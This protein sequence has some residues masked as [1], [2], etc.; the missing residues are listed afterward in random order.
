MEELFEELFD[1]LEEYINELDDETV[2]R[3]GEKRQAEYE[4]AIK[5][6]NSPEWE[7][8]AYKAVQDGD[9]EAAKEVGSERKAA[10]ANRDLRRKKLD[11]FKDL[12]AKRRSRKFQEKAAIE[13]F[14][15]KLLN[16]EPQT[17]AEYKEAARA[18]ASAQIDQG[19]RNKLEKALKVSNECLDDIMEMIEEYING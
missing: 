16:K 13:R 14:R 9:T 5:A 11:R 18:H 15:E 12:D 17:P 10:E 6:V 1:L 4:K 7:L 19:L 3:T 2:K 8:K